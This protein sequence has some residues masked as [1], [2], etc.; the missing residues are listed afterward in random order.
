MVKLKKIFKEYWFYIFSGFLFLTFGLFL[1]F[2][3]LEYIQF[4]ITYVLGISFIFVGIKAILFSLKC[5]DK[6]IKRSKWAESVIDIAIG[7]ILMVFIK[8]PVTYFFGLAFIVMPIIRFILA[9]NKKLQ[10]A[11]DFPYYLI[12]L[13]LII[14][15]PN[16]LAK[17][18]FVIIGIFLVLISIT[19]FYGI[20]YQAK[21]YKITNKE[22]KD[23]KII[24]DSTD[25]REI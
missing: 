18:M 16:L 2:A 22:K 14:F 11:N 4:V 8:E 1:I 20:Y 13:L 6:I 23:E 9:K 3:H 12:G 10:F 25:H 5:S 17:T 15:S 19:I 7:V 21:K 24:I